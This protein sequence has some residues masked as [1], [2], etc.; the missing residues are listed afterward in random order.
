[1]STRSES[2][3]QMNVRFYSMISVAVMLDSFADEMVYFK[4]EK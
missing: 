2:I 3:L 4:N 1:M